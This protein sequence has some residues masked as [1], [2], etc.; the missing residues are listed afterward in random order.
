[1]TD[2][3]SVLTEERT[4]VLNL[5]NQDSELSRDFSGSSLDVVRLIEPETQ[6]H[7]D[8]DVM[9]VSE[10][11]RLRLNRTFSQYIDSDQDT[12]SSCLT[13]TASYLDKGLS[14]TGVMLLK[15]KLIADPSDEESSSARPKLGKLMK[16][17]SMTL[18][19]LKLH[20]SGTLFFLLSPPS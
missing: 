1:M 20:K 7:Q 9:M 11:R 18:P 12:S 8:H 14:S 19:P 5:T 2:G 4:K 15:Q 10:G 3:E 17:G 16:R 13:S 6:V